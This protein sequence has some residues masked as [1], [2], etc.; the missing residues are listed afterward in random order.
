MLGLAYEVSPCSFGAPWDWIDHERSPHSICACLQNGP[1]HL[2][3]NQAPYENTFSWD[4][5]ADY[6]WID[7]PV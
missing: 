7:Q 4:R 2:D 1:I 5:V 6:I 3:A